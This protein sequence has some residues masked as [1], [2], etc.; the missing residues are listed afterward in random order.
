MQDPA[1]LHEAIMEQALWLQ[2]WVGWLVAM[3]LASIFFLKRI[4]ARFVLG[5]FLLA[6]GSMSLLYE[7]YGFQR[8]LGLAHVVF[9][10]PLLAYLWVRRPHWNLAAL[11]GKWLALLFVTNLASLIIDYIDVAR[12]LMG[13]RI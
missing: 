10:T 5:A 11:S 2:G 3:N 9:W 12:Y 8:I 7:W 13:E 4:E 1:T 6:A